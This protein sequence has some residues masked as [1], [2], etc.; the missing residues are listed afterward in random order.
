MTQPGNQPAFLIGHPVTTAAHESSATGAEVEAIYVTN[1]APTSWTSIYS[2]PISKVQ[3]ANDEHQHWTAIWTLFFGETNLLFGT[4]L[5]AFDLFHSG[6]AC[7]LFSK[8]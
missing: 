5:T 1:H 7:D 3:R 2:E 6:K 4:M 8:E